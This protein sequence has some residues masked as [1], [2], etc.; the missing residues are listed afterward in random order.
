MNIP[1]N[2]VA[3]KIHSVYFIR[4]GFWGGGCAGE[5]KVAMELQRKYGLYVYHTDNSRYGDQTYCWEYVH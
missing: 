4:G 5:T 1:D 3:Q 2:I